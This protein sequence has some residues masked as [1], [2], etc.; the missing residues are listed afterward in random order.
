[1]PFTRT[2]KDTPTDQSNNF[3]VQPIASNSSTSNPPPNNSPIKRA[4]ICAI[5]ARVAHIY[6]STQNSMP[7]PINNS[8]SSIYPHLGS[9]EDEENNMCM[10][11]DTGD[12]VNSDSLTYHLW[13]M[14]QCSEIV[15]KFIRCGD[16]TG[17]DVVQL[18]AALDVDS[19]H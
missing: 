10:L 2:N 17:Y 14:S 18:L 19:S 9:V 13:V 6:P 1:M 8:L 3:S 5:F 7:I 12:T 4:R 16:G 15:G 11:L